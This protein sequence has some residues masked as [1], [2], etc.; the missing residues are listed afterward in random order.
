MP[1]GAQAVNRINAARAPL[2]TGTSTAAL[3]D[4]PSTSTVHRRF[5]DVLTVLYTACIVLGTLIPFDFSV[6]EALQSDRSAFGLGNARSGLPD[7]M[8]NIG[9]FV[10]LG[11]LLHASLT[12]LLGRPWLAVAGTVALAATLSLTVESVQ[13]LSPTRVSSAVD[14]G[15]NVFGA[16]SGALLALVCRVPARRLLGAVR[17]ELHH[18]SPGIMVRLY[19]GL[20]LVGAVLPFT[21]TLDVQRLARA[22][23]E[24]IVVP[25]G[26]T[27]SLAVSTYEARLEGDVSAAAALQRD[28]MLCWVR[29]SAECLSFLI[30]G[31]LLHG[32]LL[33]RYG[34]GPGSRLLLAGYASVGLAAAMS[35]LQI[36]VMSRGFD[37]TDILARV[38]GSLCGYGLYGL[39]LARGGLDVTRLARPTVVVAMAYVLATGLAPFSFD[40]TLQ[41]AGDKV[42]SHSFIPFYSYHLGRFDLVCADFCTKVLIFGF[43]GIAVWWSSFAGSAPGRRRRLRI[44]GL[45]LAVSLAVEITQLFVRSRVPSLT[46]PVIAALAAW[47]AVVCAQ[48]VADFHARA[49]RPRAIRQ[50][51]PTPPQSLPPADAL[52]ATLISDLPTEPAPLE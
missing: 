4:P 49:I 37:V 11:I 3:P 10:P 17:R 46:D 19:A 41:G 42:A 24:S 33:R 22:W 43:L 47:G 52:V 28:G 9:L 1:G 50:L 36:A 7:L 27:S 18:N 2:V 23:R 21:P 13:L 34:F 12:R 8:S 31:W 15:A 25:F 39:S 14:F 16:T 26:E 5:V 44:A 45:A 38:V 6:T 30:L 40:L 51:E 32:V 20:L 48:K 29:W 35:V